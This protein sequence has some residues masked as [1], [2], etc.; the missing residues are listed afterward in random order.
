V[1]KEANHVVITTDSTV[2]QNRNKFVTAMMLFAV[3]VIPNVNI[4]EQN[5]LETGH[6]EMVVDSMHAAIDAAK[7]I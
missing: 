4:I 5:Y 6:T 7:K 2:S 1:P 3:Q